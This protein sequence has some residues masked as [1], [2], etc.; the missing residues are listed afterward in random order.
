MKALLC[1]LCIDI[2]ALDPSGAPTSCRCGNMQARW[3]DPQRGTV[4]VRAK[5]R[6]AARILGM[7]NA[8][9]LKAIDG[10]HHLEMVE[11]GG[12]WEAWRKLHVQSTDAKGYIFDKDKRACW[13]CVVKIGETGDI[14]WEEENET[15]G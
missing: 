13:A 6:S 12:Q 7:N 5:D 9:L 3:L 4:R 10:F 1:G 15:A 8:F 11:A 2:R 14:A